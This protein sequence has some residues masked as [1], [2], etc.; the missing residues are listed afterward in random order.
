LNR[1]DNTVIFEPIN[2]LAARKIINQ[3]IK[4]LKNK[5][6]LQNINLEL[7][8][9]IVNYLVKEE[10]AVKEGAR[11]LKRLVDQKITNNIAS[12]ILTNDKK[13]IKVSLNKDKF[14][15]K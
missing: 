4:Q 13:K 3:E 8:S 7:D 15:I 9:K 14:T 6:L 10:Q 11:S 1:L 12:H 2:K 5:L